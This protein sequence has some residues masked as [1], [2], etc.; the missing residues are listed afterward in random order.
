MIIKNFFKFTFLI[1]FLCWFFLSH[2]IFNVKSHKLYEIVSN[3]GLYKAEYYS[4]SMTN[5]FGL[6]FHFFD[7][8]YIV[9][10]DKNN[11]YLGQTSPFSMT[12]SVYE[13]MFPTENYKSFIILNADYEKAYEIEVYSKDFLELI[14]Q[15]FY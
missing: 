6:Y 5:F 7:G 8:V 14:L 3:D 2:V 15:Y 9:L 13:E 1:T 12:D 11:N 4:P 10:K